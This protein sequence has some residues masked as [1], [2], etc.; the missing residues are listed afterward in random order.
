MEWC[1]GIRE[2]NGKH[3]IIS[4]RKELWLDERIKGVIQVIVCTYN[5]EINKHWINLSPYIP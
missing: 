1:N 2:R 5:D 3:W 4:K